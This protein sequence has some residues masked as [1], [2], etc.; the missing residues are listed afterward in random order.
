MDS[1]VATA[2]CGWDPGIGGIDEIAARRKGDDVLEEENLRSQTNLR[3]F[4]MEEDLGITGLLR[5]VSI[6]TVWISI[7]VFQTTQSIF[8]RESFDWVFWYIVWLI[9]VCCWLGHQWL[10]WVSSNLVVTIDV[11]I[12]LWLSLVIQMARHNRKDERRR[13][14]ELQFW[15]F[16]VVVLIIYTNSWVMFPNDIS[17]TS[18]KRACDWSK[19]HVLDCVFNGSI[20][21][22]GFEVY[23]TGYRW[24][25]E[26][27][28]GFL[29]PGLSL[30]RVK[31]IFLNEGS[32]LE[33]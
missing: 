20:F 7:W 26:I 12:W 29:T 10:Y 14:N 22:C 23:I 1:V 3:R 4:A 21:W 28:M 27:L 32:Q 19:R 5:K 16:I 6:Q 25:L 30:G 11:R 2:V 9:M 18:R 24:I 8:H 31:S 13:S 17:W 15:T 33:L